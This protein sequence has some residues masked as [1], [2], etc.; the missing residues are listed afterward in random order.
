MIDSK[1]NIRQVRVPTHEDGSCLFWEFATDSYDIGFGLFFEWSKSPT[2]QVSIH[3]SDSEE[4][5]DEDDEIDEENGN[6]T[7]NFR[8]LFT[9]RILQDSLGS[10]EATL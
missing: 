4:E 2:E 10:L 7:K 3:I 6:L 8:L 1:N 9:L 5:D